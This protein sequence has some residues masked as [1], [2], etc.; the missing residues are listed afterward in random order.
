MS[1]GA[2][3][4]AC[5]TLA[6]ISSLRVDS[7]YA[8][9][10]KLIGRYDSPYVRRVG[11]S[12]H[13]LGQAFAHVPLSPFSNAAEFR[14]YAPIGRMPALVLGSGETLTESSAILD[15]L[16]ELVGPGR[17]LLPPSGE[18]RRKSMRILASAAAACDM[19]VAINYERRKS[20]GISAAWIARRREQLDAALE[21]L[22]AFRLPLPGDHGLDQV[23][24]TTACAVSYVG[25]VEPGA[26]PPARYRQL[27]RLVAACEALPALIALPQR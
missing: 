24:I 20:Q 17:A 7:R 26:A 2:G 10:V 21:E 18:Q 1:S 19:A 14:R 22:E 25:R 5:E 15:Y 6:S 11:V 16:D 9:R 12:L 3:L 8:A 13:A 23:M 27:D 4:A